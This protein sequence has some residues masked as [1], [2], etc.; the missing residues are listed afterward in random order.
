MSSQPTLGPGSLQSSVEATL[1]RLQ[2]NSQ[3]SQMPC[4]EAPRPVDRAWTG[5][6]LA[7]SAGTLP[8]I[9]ENGSHVYMRHMHSLGT[10][11]STDEAGDATLQS[12]V[13]IDHEDHPAS[14]TLQGALPP[15]G[16][17]SCGSIEQPTSQVGYRASTSRDSQPLNWYLG[18]GPAF[19]SDHDQGGSGPGAQSSH[20]APQSDSF[21]DAVGGLVLQQVF[22]ASSGDQTQ[23]LCSVASELG[24]GSGTDQGN[25]S[26]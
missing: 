12:G 5:S 25:D 26:F 9:Q 17:Q 7:T 18:P 14:L 22:S 1:A 10:R 2:A 16:N 6:D 13:W 21:A 3:Q 11:S 24:S 4:S 23:Q 20:L 19:F 8:A 15:S